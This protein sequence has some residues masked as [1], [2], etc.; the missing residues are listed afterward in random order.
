MQQLQGWS[1]LLGPPGMPAAAVARWRALLEQVAD[2]PEW[3]AGTEALGA[4]PRIR[5]VPDPGQ[6]LRHQAQFYQRLVTMLG[7]R[8]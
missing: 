5:A 1:A 2:D 6:F 4:A 7:D 8:P 3:Q